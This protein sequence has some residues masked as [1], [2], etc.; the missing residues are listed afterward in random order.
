MRKQMVLEKLVRFFGKEAAHPIFYTDKCW[1]EEE[2]T[3]GCY[4]GLMAPNTLTH[5]GPHLRTPFGNVHFA[6]TE[7]ADRWN[8]YLDGAIQSGYRAAAEVLQT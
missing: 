1:T 6:G 8:G 5:F 7:T 2:W 4:V 3:R